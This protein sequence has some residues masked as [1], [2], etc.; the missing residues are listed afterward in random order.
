MNTSVRIADIPAEN[1]IEHLQNIS[2]PLGQP[3]RHGG[4]YINVLAL[5]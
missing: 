5:K 1:R 4:I 2:L 3:G